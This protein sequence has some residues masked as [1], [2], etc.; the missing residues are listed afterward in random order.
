MNSKSSW[1]KNLSIVFINELKYQMKHL[2]IGNHQVKICLRWF[3][4]I[5]PSSLS[6]LPPFLASPYRL[7]Q[8][9]HGLLP[10]LSQIELKINFANIFL[11]ITS[12]LKNLHWILFTYRSHAQPEVITNFLHKGPD[13]KY[14]LLWGSDDLFYYSSLPS[15]V[16]QKQ[17]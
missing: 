6:P 9:Y 4:N 1:M 14:P 11:L 8:K 12:I 17:P 16:V 3:F 7:H 13:N 10:F 15:A 2:E 5:P